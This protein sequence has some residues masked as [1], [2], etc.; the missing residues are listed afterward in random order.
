ML[1]IRE[2]L[3]P[4]DI[5]ELSA[6][7]PKE[8]LVFF[9]IETTGLRAGR[10][11]LY[12]IGLLFHDGKDWELIQWFSQG[13]SDEEE[14]LLRFSG[15][16][17]DMRR[18]HSPQKPI[19]I[20]Y[21]GDGFDI[22]FISSCLRA[23]GLPDI[24][25]TVLSF[26]L[27]KQLRGLKRILGLPDMKLKTI[28]RFLGID[29]EDSFS[30]GELISVYERYRLLLAEG[31]GEGEKL[32]SVLLLHNAED[33][34]NMP[35]I[36]RMLSYEG[37]FSGDFSF[38]SG[39]ILRISGRPVLDLRYSLKGPLPRELYYEDESYVLSASPEND[40]LLDL[41]VSLY[42]GELKYFFADHKNYYYLPAEDRAIHKS[43][44]SFVDRK[45]RKQATKATCYQKREGL[46][47]PEPEAIFAPVYY[48]DYGADI[49]YAEFCGDKLADEENMKR[50]AVSVLGYVQG[51]INAQRGS[52]M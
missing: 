50:Y 37:L 26:D 36:C 22:P 32:L 30:G 49:R 18:R 14:L 2:K 39:E 52:K 46:F 10:A 23:Y 9:D 51:K 29:R 7:G 43:V 48:K 11:E 33:I 17:N 25:G 6:I 12:L 27:Y 41:A 35:A 20:S 38:S 16:L 31:S 40:D 8:R 34:R 47:L 44:A 24:K 19:L 1:E 13:L 4:M 5:P 3:E 42:E 15:F 21:N 28:E 45:S